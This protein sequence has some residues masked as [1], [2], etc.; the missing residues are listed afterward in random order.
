MLH[1]DDQS[2]VVSVAPPLT[3]S[4]VEVVAGL[5]GVGAGP[6]RVWP[7]QPGRRSPWLPCAGGCCLVAEA[8][9]GGDP[10]GWLRFL[11]REVLA[12]VARDA[13]ARAERIG[14]P[15]GH[16]VDGEVLLG[17]LGG[18][19]LLVAAGRRVRVAPL[20][21]DLLPLAAPRRRH[22]G[23]V[24]QLAGHPTT[25]ERRRRQSTER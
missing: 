15:G 18:P 8:R 2:Q 4:E 10:A 25:E 17:G 23:E 19:R 14:L 24:V 3:A 11:V 12:P 5:A 13:L 6:R 16:R 21:D 22:R 20:D 7:G 9:P 1:P